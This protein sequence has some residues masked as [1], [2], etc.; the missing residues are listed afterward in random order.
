MRRTISWVLFTLLLVATSRAEAQSAGKNCLDILLKGTY[1]ID[2]EY[3][4]EPTP[5]VVFTVYCHRAA[6]PGDWPMDYLPLRMT[7]GEVNFSQYTA[8]GGSPG[9]DVQTWYTKVR[10]D[11]STM[12]IDISDKTFSNSIGS[13]TFGG[14]VTSVPYAA[15]MD[16]A[17][18]TWPGSG[19][20]NIDLT[21]TPFEINDTFWASG[22]RP[23]GSVTFNGVTLEVPGN[24]QP[25]VL[26]SDTRSVTIRGGGYCGGVGPQGFNSS[27][28]QWPFPPRGMLALNLKYSP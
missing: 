15:A 19:V 13:L 1:D 17:D 27:V 26:V 3:V 9:T 22:Y 23:K 14:T 24:M 2:R 12:M 8:G 10:I 21:D 11:T 25:G 4:I 18:T 20:A 16:C 5:G 28:A 7:G 6:G